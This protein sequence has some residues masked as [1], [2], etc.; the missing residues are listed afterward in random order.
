[1]AE[2]RIRTE[3]FRDQR[4]RSLFDEW[5]ATLDG[6]TRGVIDSHMTKFRAG[7][8]GNC[9]PLGQ[10]LLELKID[11]GPGYRV[12]FVW[13]SP[14]SVLLLRAGDKSTQRR[15]IKR[16]LRDWKIWRNRKEK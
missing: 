4:G 8:L 16:A 7:L 15:D 9:E 14:E 11:F 6:R 1:M 3:T 12:Y 13:T 2:A 5:M 10:G